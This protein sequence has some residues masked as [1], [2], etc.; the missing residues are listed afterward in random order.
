VS[1]NGTLTFDTAIS[2]EFVIGLMAADNYSYYLF[3]AG[4]PVSSLT[5]DSTA[6]VALNRNHMPQGLSHRTSMSALRPSR[7]PRR[8]R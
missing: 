1:T 3:N 8:T 6:G 4:S 5:F 2:G 7:N